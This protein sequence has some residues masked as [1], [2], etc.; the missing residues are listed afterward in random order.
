MAGDDASRAAGNPVAVASHRAAIRRLGAFMTTTA[1]A[2][3]F[4]G[5]GSQAVGMGKDLADR[6]P[7]AARVFEEANDAIGVDLRAL[8]F[9]GPQDEL[10]KTAN[11]QPALV[12][13]S[14]AAFRAAEEAAGARLPEPVVV[15]GHSLGEFSALVA[16]GALGLADA[17]RLVR[18]R[19]ELM[20]VADP[21][22]AMAAVIGLDAYVIAR[23]L[24]G[25]RVVV[26]NDNA[27]GQVVI[28]GPRLELARVADDLKK[29]G[30]KRVI[31]LRVSA[32]FHSPAMQAAAPRLRQAIDVTP[33]NALRYRLIA[34]VDAAVHVH[35]REMPALLEKQVWSPVQWV[36][37]VKRAHGEGASAFVEFGPGTVLTG[38]V[39]R[40][41]PHMATGNVSDEGTLRQSLPLLK[42]D[43]R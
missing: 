35:A 42:G 34:N 2:W 6:Y 38:L 20:Q 33:F 9:D 28:S 29:I 10:D 37:S 17:V 3:L 4:P 18:T 13:A 11:T 41:L 24:V 12:A 14:I 21:A 25:S 23:A 32:A 36:A 26:A 30:A 31:P 22:G 7:S 40:I 8:C 27:P 15:L 19:G 1:V 16:A 5:Q 39:K 43:A